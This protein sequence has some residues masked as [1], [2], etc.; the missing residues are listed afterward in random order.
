MVRQP[1]LDPFAPPSSVKGE[2][3]RKALIPAF[4]LILGALVLSVTV[5]GEP[6]AGA[7]IPFS[8]VIVGNTTTNPVPVDVQNTD[9]AGNLKV[10][11]QGTAN[12]DV[13]NSSLPVSVQN[14][15]ANGNIK[16]HEQGTVPSSQSGTWTVGL[17]GTPGVTSAD[18]TTLV[19]A[20]S[21][22][23]EG[24]GTIIDPINFASIAQYKT[25]RVMAN[26][27]AGA[28]CANIAVSVYTDAGGRSYLIDTFP[29]Q[30]FLSQTRVFD[31]LGGTI[32]VELQNNN[33]AAVTNI[34]VAVFGRAN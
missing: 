33:P 14:T 16:V 19:S 18:Q 10:H 29:M 15:D 7:S 28:A 26:C 17:N 9:A 1:T 4:L 12:V 8:N 34:G 23:L 32:S 6:L 27:F 31:T 25:V 30:N 5:F 13:T 3:M 2:V 11:E 20:F 21:G 24:S 22:I